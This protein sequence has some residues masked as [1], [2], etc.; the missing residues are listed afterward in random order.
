M[1][2]IEFGVFK[3][4]NCL[5]IREFPLNITLRLF[6]TYI[7]DD[8]GVSLFHTYVCATLLL[9]WSGKLKKLNFIDLLGFF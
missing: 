5:L 8:E 2:V 9:K 7:S 1:N 3:W 4:I 6:D